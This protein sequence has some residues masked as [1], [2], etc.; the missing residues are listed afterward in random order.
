MAGEERQRFGHI[1]QHHVRRWS[2]SEFVFAERRHGSNQR[3]YPL[4]S[5]QVVFD[6]ALFDST[7]TSAC[8]LGCFTWRNSDCTE[9]R[10]FS[11]GLLS[12]FGCFHPIRIAAC[13]MVSKADNRVGLKEQ[14]SLFGYRKGLQAFV[15]KFEFEPLVM[16]L[17]QRSLGP[18]R[19]REHG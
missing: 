15:L 10:L 16:M 4:I 2:A 6:L 14:F 11:R 8:Y 3:S 13:R 7:N 1:R 9:Y 5:Q 18:R 19:C 12:L 17:L